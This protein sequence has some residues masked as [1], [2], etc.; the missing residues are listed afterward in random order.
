MYTNTNAKTANMHKQEVWGPPGARLLAGGSSGLLTSSSSVSP[1]ASN[2]STS[3]DDVLMIKERLSNSVTG[4]KVQRTKR[5]LHSPSPRF[6]VSLTQ[7]NFSE[8]G[9]IGMNVRVSWTYI[10]FSWTIGFDLFLYS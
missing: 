2:V 1:S 5:R 3:D 6:I 7:P 4:P 8:S 10:S 9:I